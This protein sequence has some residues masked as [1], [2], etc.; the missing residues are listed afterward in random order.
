[1]VAVVALASLLTG[2]EAGPS[3]AAAAPGMGSWGPV[4]TWGLQ[5]KHM[6]VLPTGKVLVW[7]N[8][9]SA[10]IWDPAAGAQGGFTATAPAVF[11]DLHCAGNATL[12]DGRSIVLGGQNGAT[13]VGIAVNGL[14]DA[15]TETWS[16]GAPMAYSR[17]YPSV[18]TLGDGR[19]LATSGDDVDGKRITTPEVYDPRTDTWTKLTGAVRNQALYPHMYVLPNGKVF[20]AA[21][22]SATAILDPSGTGS[23]TAGPS[24]GWSTNGYSESSVMYEPGKIL[25]AGGGDPAI[26]RTAIIDMNQSSPKWVETS[27]MAYPR[28]RMNLVLLA[29]GE[30]LA[31]G[32]TAEAD[33]E[34]RAV[35]PAEIWN[36]ETQTWRT[37][38]AMTEA[39][40]YHSSAVLLPDGRVLS[41]GGEAAGRLRAQIYSPPYLSAGPRPTVT[42]APEKAAFGSTISI[43]SPDAAGI[44]TVALIRLNA[45]THAWDQ[46]QRYVPLAFSRSG[47]TLNATAPAT[48]NVAPP[49][50]Y[51]LVVENGSGIPSAARMITIDS[52]SAL[53]PGSVA[54]TVTDQN[55]APIPGA[56]VAGAGASDTTDGTGA[57]RLDGL[58]GGEREI[59]ASAPGKAQVTKS[60]LVTPGATANL[61]F[62][63]SPPGQVTGRVT[64]QPSGVPLSGASVTYPG[65]VATTDSTGA[66]AIDE[67]PAGPLTLD[68]T[69]LGHT[70]QRRQV[71]VV[72]GASSTQ[73]FALAKAPTYITG[74]LTDRVTGEPIAGAPVSVDGGGSAVTDALGRYRIDVGPG[75]YD[76]TAAAPGYVS[77]TGHAIV[78]DGG[79]TLLDFPMEPI[80]PPASVLKHL[81]FEGASLTDASTGADKVSGAVTRDTASPLAGAASAKLS[82]ATSAYL[83]ETVPATNDLWVTA[84]VRPASLPSGDARIVMVQNDGTT[85]GALQLRATGRLRLRQGSTTVG[86][87]SAPLAAGTT[88]R[89]GLHQVRGTGSTAVLEAYQAPVGS[90]FGAPFARTATGT[91]TTAATRVRLGATSGPAVSASFDDVFVDAGSPSGGGTTTT[92]SATSSTTSSTSTSTST[93]STPGGGMTMTFVATADAQVK[94]TSPTKNYGTLD[95]LRLR[96]GTASSP[97]EY[98]TLVRFAPT[99]MGTVTSAKL[100]LYVTDASKAGGSVFPTSS[101]WVEQ[102]VTWATAPS[103]TGPALATVGTAAKG[104]ITYDVT[105]AVQAGTLDFLMLSPSTDSLITS[106]REG[107]NPPE[108]VIT[109]T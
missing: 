53:V 105:T 40:M 68:V 37:V 5:G 20:E 16:Q 61:S 23:W 22:G 107:A 9:S 48:G 94:S 11:G 64:E 79:Y 104:W 2:A 62:Q 29:D 106:S 46:N 100:R 42:S 59:V 38:S 44:T 85:V 89:I 47:T 69:A 72:S 35:L 74:G 31:V 67:L 7:S 84:L 60:V 101:G 83:E 98:R 49:G 45:D 8:G 18:T 80:A 33:E 77:A 92:T 4:Q 71:T 99:A 13:H 54:G 50:V 27:P 56:T 66:Y 26:A 103:A 14:F 51:Q 28:R 87:E 15:T 58:S 36:P 52:A 55:G 73:D 6:I 90:S 108:L 70:G 82:A 75:H 76:V 97:E 86:A 109:H 91:W 41:A 39:R 19:V 43:G 21:P 32:G 63:L 10:R 57:Y 96:A 3:L 88:Y 65:G 25:R 30:V 17:W 102:A 1:M 24:N 12:A 93:T 78:T 34:D 81:T 95:V